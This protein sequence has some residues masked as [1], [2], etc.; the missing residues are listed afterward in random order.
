MVTSLDIYHR[1]MSL[2]L[3]NK[4]T[5]VSEVPQKYKNPMV[6][7]LSGSI[8]GLLSAIVLQPF[9]LVKTR[10]QQTNNLQQK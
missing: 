1:K 4:E 8:S 5:K 2:K 7:L 10:L 6:H 3:S 9:D